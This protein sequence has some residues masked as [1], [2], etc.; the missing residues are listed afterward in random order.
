MWLQLKCWRHRASV[1]TG[2]NPLSTPT[3]P[4]TP[5][6]ATLP[7][8]IWGFYFQS[9]NLS[10][11]G[12]WW[13]MFHWRFYYT[14]RTAKATIAAAY[15][16]NSLTYRSNRSWLCL[17]V[18]ARLAMCS[19]FLDLTVHGGD[20][21]ASTRIIVTQYLNKIKDCISVFLSFFLLFWLMLV[22]ERLLLP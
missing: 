17:S 8:D 4:K 16:I 5:A 18:S 14:F 6:S 15:R 7:V 21:F 19:F 10:T 12:T 1:W 13:Q 11:R 22:V 3:A 9:G 2:D 20:L